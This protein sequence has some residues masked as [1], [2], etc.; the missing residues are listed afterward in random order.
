MKAKLKKERKLKWPLIAGRSRQQT[1]QSEK[2]PSTMERRIVQVLNQN[3]ALHLDQLDSLDGDQYTFPNIDSLV[4]FYS[5]FDRLVTTSHKS[6]RMVNFLNST[7]ACCFSNGQLFV[8]C[9]A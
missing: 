5:S 3:G 7:H 1:T 6:F 8:F 2:N 4:C 9:V